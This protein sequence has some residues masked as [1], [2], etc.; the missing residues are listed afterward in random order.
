MS[1]DNGLTIATGFLVALLHPFPSAPH[2]SAC[3]GMEWLLTAWKTGFFTLFICSEQSETPEFLLEGSW[4]GDGQLL[5]NFLPPAAPSEQRPW[6]LVA[7]E[8]MLWHDWHL[9]GPSS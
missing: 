9:Q 4:I 2:Y 1:G 6:C 8:S 3:L 7:G 5:P